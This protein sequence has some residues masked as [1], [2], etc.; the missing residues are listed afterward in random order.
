MLS[1]VLLCSI[2]YEIFLCKNEFDMLARGFG[3]LY[4]KYVKL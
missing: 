3:Y 1:Y 2:W 4:A